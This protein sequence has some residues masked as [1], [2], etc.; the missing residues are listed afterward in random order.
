MICFLFPFFRYFVRNFFF[1][2][3]FLSCFI[4]NFAVANSFCAYS[5]SLGMARTEG[6][7][8]NELRR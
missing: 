1:F 6:A 8:H 2:D 7:L 4:C 3:L 5:D